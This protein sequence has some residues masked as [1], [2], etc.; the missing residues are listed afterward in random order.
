MFTIHENSA[1]VSFTVRVHPRA[2]HDVIVGEMGDA[3]KLALKA[4]PVEGRANEACIEFFAKL[5]KV[6][7]SSVTIASGEKNRLKVVR[8][9]G[10]SAEQLR[11][12]LQATGTSSSR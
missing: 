5:L 3:L 1:G 2:K 4:P 7:R 6:S 11:Q 10:I 12:R 9:S 8:I